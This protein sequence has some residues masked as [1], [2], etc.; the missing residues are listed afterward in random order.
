MYGYDPLLFDLSVDPNELNNLSNNEE[1]TEIKDDLIK[2]AHTNHD[3]KKY[4]KKIRKSQK[5]RL[6]LRKISDESDTD[7]NW[8]FVAEPGDENRFVRGGGLKKGAHAT[9]SRYLIPK[10]KEAQQVTDPTGDPK[11]IP[12]PNFS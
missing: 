7:P 8:A 11:I 6:F 9:K 3:P 2:I 4:N 12:K 1:Y 5:E 10:V